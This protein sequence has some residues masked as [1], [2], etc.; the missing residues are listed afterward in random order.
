MAHGLAK[1]PPIAGPIMVPIDHTKGITAYA[2]AF[3]FSAFM[4]HFLGAN[5]D[6]TLVFGILD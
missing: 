3:D 6:L 5:I 2:R 4:L 1:K